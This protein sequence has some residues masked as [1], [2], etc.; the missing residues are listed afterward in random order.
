MRNDTITVQLQCVADMQHNLNNNRI[1]K[2]SLTHE[3]PTRNRITQLY[4]TKILKISELPPKALNNTQNQDS[5]NMAS[6]PPTLG[7]YAYPRGRPIKSQT[8][9]NLQNSTRNSQQ[10]QHH[11]DR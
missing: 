1:T 11:H 3:H 9:E 5:S 7:A 4:Q 8:I 10:H 6:I 2:H